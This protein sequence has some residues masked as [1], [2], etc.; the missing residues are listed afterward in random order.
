MP[1]FTEQAVLE[2]RKA[3]TLGA[4]SH[5]DH[6]LRADR[7]SAHTTQKPF[8]GAHNTSSNTTVSPSHPDICPS[9]LAPRQAFSV[10][11]SQIQLFCSARHKP[12]NLLENVCV[13]FW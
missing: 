11:L 8:P 7:F 5:A 6:S 12:L 2:G 3:V 4:L 13:R 9:C 10:A 1:R